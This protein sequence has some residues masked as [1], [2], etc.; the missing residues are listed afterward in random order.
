MRLTDDENKNNLFDDKGINPSGNQKIEKEEDK[1][2]IN[3]FTNNDINSKEDDNMNN[4]EYDGAIIDPK[5]NYDNQYDLEGDK[6]EKELNYYDFDEE[7]LLYRP[8]EVD[9]LVKSLLSIL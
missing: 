4:I 2:N 1:S 6:I 3:S 8:V 5:I 7:L 9:K